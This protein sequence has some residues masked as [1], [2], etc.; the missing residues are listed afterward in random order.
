MSFEL[1]G[2]KSHTTM[3]LSYLSNQTLNSTVLKY[4]D[5]NGPAIAVFNDIDGM[6]YSINSSL[7]LSAAIASDFI[8]GA[9]IGVGIVVRD[10]KGDI[11]LQEDNYTKEKTIV[12]TQ[13]GY[14]SIQY[15]ARD[16]SG[17]VSRKNSSIR[18]KDDVPPIIAVNDTVKTT[19]K[20]GETLTYPSATVTDNYS[21]NVKLYVYLVFPTGQIEILSADKPYVFTG[22]GNYQLSYYSFDGDFNVQRLTYSISVS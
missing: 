3:N 17:N 11:V 8:D 22:A 9:N 19:Y 7:T 6:S 14:Y 13:Y 18:V 15:I 5:L 20:V 4:G 2:V 1:C 12:L 10:P 21:E 16:G